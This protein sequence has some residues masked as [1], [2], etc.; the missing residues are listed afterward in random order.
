MPVCRLRNCGFFS[1]VTHRMS[2]VRGFLFSGR[3]WACMVWLRWNLLPAVC[4]AV[5]QVLACNCALS[6]HAQ[7]VEIECWCGY[8]WAVV[9][10]SLLVPLL[11]ELGGEE[12]ACLHVLNLPVWWTRVAEWQV[13]QGAE[14]T[15]ASSHMFVILLYK[16]KIWGLHPH[17]GTVIS[18]PQP[19]CTRLIPEQVPRKVFTCDFSS[20]AVSPS[21]RAGALGTLSDMRILS[22]QSKLTWVLRRW[23]GRRW[24]PWPCAGPLNAG[25]PQPSRQHPATRVPALRG[26]SK[27][28]LGMWSPPLGKWLG[29]VVRSR[30]SL[31]GSAGKWPCCGSAAVCLSGLA[32]GCGVCRIWQCQES[33]TWL[34]C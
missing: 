31:A 8:S 12:P 32:G 24:C 19:A 5:L 23:G 28:A 17:S 2:A 29:T 22:L 10:S 6:A 9:L 21:A 30:S 1:E 13:C 15:D 14:L 18:A 11:Q 25:L 34:A 16:P 3:C 20:W 26:P 7:S 33:V 27:G 4:Q